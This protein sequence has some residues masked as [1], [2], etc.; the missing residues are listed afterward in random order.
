M[1]FKMLEPIS[2]YLKKKQLV[3]YSTVTENRNGQFAK[4]YME[5]SGLTILSTFVEFFF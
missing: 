2:D 5:G 3:E 1:R 4:T